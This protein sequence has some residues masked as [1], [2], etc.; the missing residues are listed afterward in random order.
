MLYLR[1]KKF[2]MDKKQNKTIK[3]LKN[4]SITDYDS[5]C[6][7]DK[8]FINQEL[9]RVQYSAK[10]SKLKRARSKGDRERLTKEIDE[11]KELARI[12]AENIQKEIENKNKLKLTEQ[13]ALIDEE[14]NRMI[15]ERQLK[16]K[17]RK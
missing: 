7:V 4:F 14:V 5:N 17:K 15:K 13:E 11:I 12:N 6:P 1:R 9:L 10:S 3:G 8:L 16:P 2:K